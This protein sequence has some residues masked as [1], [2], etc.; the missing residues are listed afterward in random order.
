MAAIN[1][2][3]GGPQGIRE[4]SVRAST[5]TSGTYDDGSLKVHMQSV[6]SSGGINRFGTNYSSIYINTNRL[7]T[8]NAPN[9]SQVPTALGGLTQPAIAPFWMDANIRS[10]TATSTNNNY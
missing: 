9:T 2:G 10:G 5:L 3:L 1:T 6:F 8:F 7:I 4:G